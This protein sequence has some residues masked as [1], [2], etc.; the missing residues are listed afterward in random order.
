MRLVFLC[1]FASFLQTRLG[2]S[3]SVLWHNAPCQELLKAISSLPTERSIVGQNCFLGVLWVSSFRGAHK[4]SCQ[5]PK[6]IESKQANST[7]AVL[8][9][10]GGVNSICF[11]YKLK[12]W[13]LEEFSQW[14]VVTFGHWVLLWFFHNFT[15]VRTC[16]IVE[17]NFRRPLTAIHRE[18]LGHNLTR[19]E[20]QRW[21]NEINLQQRTWHN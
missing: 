18:K 2:T 3:V 6:R 20:R 14:W 1:H 12:C 10:R 9:L 5:C 21:R 13:L 17:S 8:L 11:N 4:E 15:S 16:W 19:G 7:K